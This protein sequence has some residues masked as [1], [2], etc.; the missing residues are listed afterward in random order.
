MY[1]IQAYNVKN[2][3]TEI[4]IVHSMVDRDSTIKGLRANLD[5]GLITFE[6]SP[7]NAFYR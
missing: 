7:R 3:R 1:R 4:I 6:Y 5:Y 2:Q